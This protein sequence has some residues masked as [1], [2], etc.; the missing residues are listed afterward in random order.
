MSRVWIGYVESDMFFYW[1]IEF[2]LT[3][4]KKKVEPSSENTAANEGGVMIYR[5][6]WVTLLQILFWVDEMFASIRVSQQK[7]R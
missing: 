3:R 6:K 4:K 5:N 7:Q 2:S 1:N